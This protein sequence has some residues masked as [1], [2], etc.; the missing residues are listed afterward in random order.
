MAIA[1]ATAVFP[2]PTSPS[3]TASMRSPEEAFERSLSITSFCPP[4]YPSVFFA[5]V[6]SKGRFSINLFIV[7]TFFN[8]TDV[9]SG[10]PDSRSFL[11]SSNQRRSLNI[12]CFLALSISLGVSGWWIFFRASLY[13]RIPAVSLISFSSISPCISMHFSSQNRKS[14][15][16]I[17]PFFGYTG[18][19]PGLNRNSGTTSGSDIDMPYTGSTDTFP[20]T[21]TS[22][23]V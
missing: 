18:T 23:P 4:E 11:L 7:L 8:T 19:I 16:F 13:G 21:T 17:E 22:I 2:H 12:S 3:M 1:P 5:D 20:V 9:V 14:S 10:L 15:C 6:S